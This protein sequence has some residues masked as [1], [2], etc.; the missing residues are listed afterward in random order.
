MANKK[1]APTQKKSVKRSTVQS[2]IKTRTLKQANYSSFKLAKRKHH[3]G[4]KPSNSFR[5][6][7]L[8]LS[9]LWLH[10]QLFAGIVGIYL[11]VNLLLVRGFAFTADLG[12]AKDAI[13]ELTSGSVGQLV[14]SFAVLGILVDS[15]SPAGEAANVYQTF[16]VI[17]FSLIMIWALR[18]TF[19]NVTISLRDAMYKSTYPL[20]QFLIVLF[21]VGLQMLPFIAASFIYGATIGSGLASS[22]AEI[23]AWSFLSFLLILWSI[24]MVT[25]SLFALYI[26]TLPDMTPLRALRSAKGLVQFRR[27]TV[28]RKVLFIPFACIAIIGLVMIPVIYI[29]TPAA[30]V[31]F[32]IL[33]ASVIACVHSYVYVLYRELLA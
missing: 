23:I 4:P 24:Y 19:A 16:L 9:H 12:T 5:L 10:K 30:E 6:L 18:Q 3:P 8:A 27:W 26:V 28:M 2:V 11:V 7:R 17:L 13:A 32:L 29:V 31:I 22:L 21:V 1:S 33:S 15:A 20:I 14:G 25:S